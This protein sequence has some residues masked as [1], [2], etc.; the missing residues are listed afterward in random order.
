MLHRPPCLQHEYEPNGNDYIPRIMFADPNG[1]V[2][3]RGRWG[4][5]RSSAWLHASS[6]PASDLGSR[7]A[8]LS[9]E[10]CVRAGSRPLG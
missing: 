7:N 2:G 9:A 8:L 3:G 4:R 1:K 10:C 5:P 6:S